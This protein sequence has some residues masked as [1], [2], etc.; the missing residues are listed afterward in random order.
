[1]NNIIKKLSI[2]LSLPML[3]FSCNNDSDAEP[4]YT[5]T[6]VVSAKVT[7]KNGDIVSLDS[8]KS[9]YNNKKFTIEN[10]KANFPYSQIFGEYLVCDEQWIDFWGNEKPGNKIIKIIGYK[11]DKIVFENEIN[12]RYDGFNIFTEEG[13]SP[14]RST[15]S[16]TGCFLPDYNHIQICNIIVPEEQRFCSPELK[17]INL[18][19]VDNKGNPI[20]LDGY[21]VY[22]SDNQI[23]TPYEIDSDE[24]REAQKTGIYNVVDDRILP[25]FD[26]EAG[27]QLYKQI[28][29]S[30]TKDKQILFN[31]TIYIGA[32]ECHIIYTDYE[33]LEITITQ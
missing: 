33:P 21:N 22:N 27:M 31:K 30:G 7:Y 14:L 8:I 17:T 1:M 11:N 16:E 32:G 23:I 4:T 28:N 2:L 29:I 13:S 19:V 26:K 5:P 20:A 25:E 12:I 10:R 3:F 6:H 9:Y 18:K 15:N 24:F